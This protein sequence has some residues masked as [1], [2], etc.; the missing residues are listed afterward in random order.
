MMST[1]QTL[2]QKYKQ[3]QNKTKCTYI[4]YSTQINIF[5]SKFLFSAYNKIG[6]KIRNKNI[7]PNFACL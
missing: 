1:K 3:K 2:K 7:I 4:N 5:K 6:Q